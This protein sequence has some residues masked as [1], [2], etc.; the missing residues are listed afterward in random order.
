MV[1]WH[2][3]RKKGNKMGYDSSATTTTQI[4]ILDLVCLNL[5]DWVVYCPQ[6]I[7]IFEFKKRKYRGH[8]AN[9]SHIEL[10]NYDNGWSE[11]AIKIR[12]EDGFEMVLKSPLTN[13]T[14]RGFVGISFPTEWR[15]TDDHDES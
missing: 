3:T 15:I 7:C 6:H 9:I 5:G 14:L 2:N 11:T 10:R 4:E 13:R 1:L 8:R 12:F